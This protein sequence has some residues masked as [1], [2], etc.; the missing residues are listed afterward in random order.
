MA[1]LYFLTEIC[2]LFTFR[3]NLFA[4]ISILTDFYQNGEGQNPPKL[5]TS[6]MDA[7]KRDLTMSLQ[8]LKKK[9]FLLGP[10]GF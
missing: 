3:A 10:S 9:I 4:K 7:Q 5:T 2:C 6:F 8:F 1:P